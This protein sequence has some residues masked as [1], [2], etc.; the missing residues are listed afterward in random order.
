[1]PSRLVENENGVSACRDL[2]G[3]LIEMK[4][5]GLGVAERQHERGTGAELWTDRAE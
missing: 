4:L 2:G 1:M 3:D 5:H